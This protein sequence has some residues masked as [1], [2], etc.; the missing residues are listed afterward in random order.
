MGKESVVS[1][2]GVRNAGKRQLGE[3]GRRKRVITGAKETEIREFLAGNVR[4]PGL[5]LGREL[6]QMWTTEV[7]ARRLGE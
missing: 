2:D 6:D 1:C 3:C 7:V 5:F 4:C